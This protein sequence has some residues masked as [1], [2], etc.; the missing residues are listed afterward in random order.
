MAL[1]LA[2]KLIVLAKY[3]DFAVIFLKKAANILLEQTRAN[4]HAIKLEQDKQPPYRLI[5]S[6]GL[7][8]LKIFNI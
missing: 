5:Y 2:K 4:K 1:L 7:V 8:E 3:S 6:L